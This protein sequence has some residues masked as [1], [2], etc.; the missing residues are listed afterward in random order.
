MTVS[1]R[2]ST[3]ATGANNPRK[4]ISV[5]RWNEQHRLTGTARKALWFDPDGEASELHLPWVTPEMFGAEAG[6]DISNAIEAAAE[7]L[8]GIG[9]GV[10]DFAGIDAYADNVI[11]SGLSNIRMV[12][13]G[14][15]IRRPEGSSSTRPIFNLKNGCEKIEISGFA[16]IDGGF[17]GAATVS[18]GE[19]PVILIG[20]DSGAGGLGATNR[21]ITIANNREITGGNWAAIMVYARSNSA[22]TVTPHNSNIFIHHNGISDSS[23]GVFIYKNADN[24]HVDDNDISDIGY[25][26]IIFDTRAESDVVT[27]GAITNV[28]CNRNT[29][30]GFGSYG[31]GVG[32]LVKGL[33]SDVRGSGNKIVLRLQ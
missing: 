27:S 22:G 17:A 18:T 10:L 4:Q 7:H 26:G 13:S 20:D 16:L 11:L 32:I 23:N 24:I 12:G 6:E 33:V 21:D 5:T 29:I 8:D 28:H 15:K 30:D 19:R 1:L 31:Y 14:A 25:D 3:L 9:G 2:H